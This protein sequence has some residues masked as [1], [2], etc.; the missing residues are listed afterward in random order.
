MS[1]CEQLPKVFSAN[2][3][4]SLCVAVLRDISAPSAISRRG[5]GTSTTTRSRGGRGERLVGN[6]ARQAGLCPGASS[7]QRSSLRIVLRRSALRFFAI[8]PRPPRFRVAVRDLQPRRG[9]AGDAEN[10]LLGTA[11]ARPGYVRVRAVTKGLLC[12]SFS[13][14]LRCGSSRY[15]RALRDFASRFGNFNHDA[16]PRGTRRR[17]RRTTGNGARQA[18]LCPGA[19]S[20][21]RS[22]LRIVL[23]RSALRF[24]AISMSGCERYQRSSCESFASRSRRFS[25]RGSGT[26]TTTRRRGGRGERL[27]GNGARQAGLCPGASSYQRSSLRIVL[28]RSALRFFAIS[29]RPPRFRVA[30]RDLQPRRGAAGDAEHYYRDV[31][32]QTQRRTAENDP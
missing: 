5:S 3:S 1:G 32:R 14:A 23:R 12:E 25:R 21:Q 27:V 13:V 6:G 20:Y 31:E 10:D 26:S 29:P 17:L 11:L 28:R 22:S 18:G 19:S 4:P 24:F 8:S 16:E 9:D 2:R 30:V 7:Y 15:L